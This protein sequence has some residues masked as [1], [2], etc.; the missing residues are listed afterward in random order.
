MDKRRPGSSIRTRIV[1]STAAIVLVPLVVLGAVVLFSLQQLSSDAGNSV[2]QSRTAL[3]EQV[4]TANLKD[5]AEDVAGE[6][7]IYLLERVKDAQVWA[8][9]PLVREASGSAADEAFEQRLAG[10]SPETLDARFAEDPS[11]GTSPEAASY[12]ASQIETSGAFAEMFFTDANGYNAAYSAKT[13]DFVQSDEEWWQAA[14]TKG[15]DVSPIAYDD[16]AQTFS[17]DIAVRIDSADGKKL[18]VLKAV[19]DLGVVQQIADG[20][21]EDRSITILNEDGLILAETATEHDAERIMNPDVVYAD[22]V[23]PEV[24]R[25]LEAVQTSG[26]GSVITDE[27]AVGAVLSGRSEQPINDFAGFDWTVVVEQP[28]D[29]AFAPIASIGEVKESIDGAARALTILVV[30]VLVLVAVAAFAVA[31]SLAVRIVRPILRLRDAADDV[32][33]TRLPE[34]VDS[35]DRLQPGEHLPALE[36][37]QV[38]TGD[39]IEELSDKFNSVIDTAT[40]LAAEQ[41]ESRRRNVSTA[42]VSMGRRNQSLIGRQLKVLDD[43]ERNESDPDALAGLFTLDQLATR[44]RRNAESL[45]VLAGLEPT[46]TWSQPMSLHDVVR[47]ALSEIEDFARI[48]I[49]DI[50]EAYLPGNLVSEVA[51][52]VAELCENATAFSPPT[53]PVRV[54]GFLRQD[55]YRLSITDRGIGMTEEQLYEAN[56]KLRN[57]AGFDRAPS[58]YLGHFV[59]GRLAAR[60][61]IEVRLFEPADQGLIARVTI[62]TSLLVTEAGAEPDPSLVPAQA[63]GQQQW[64]PPEPAYGA[65]GPA[66]TAY[67][68]VRQPE[69]TGAGYAP[70]APSG[71]YGPGPHPE[72]NGAGH[73]AGPPQAPPEPQWQ[74]PQWELP[75]QP[76][77]QPPPP[78]EWAPPQRPGAAPS[79][80]V[81]GPPPVPVPPRR[82]PGAP[83]VV[84]PPRFGGAPQPPGGPPEP[85]AP[86]PFRA[87]AYVPEPTPSGGTDWSTTPSP[88]EVTASGFRVRERKSPRPPAP[89]RPA[90]ATHAPRPRSAEE[91][92]STLSSF[93]T[94]VGQGRRELTEPETT[95]DRHPGENDR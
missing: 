79:P 33:T 70:A 62:P 5:T 36:P 86:L 61:G 48:D 39:E 51:H 68:T 8:A 91:A 17:S 23:D 89:T 41:V 40:R 28:T 9:D 38:P 84:T 80:P 15:V 34:L 57:P 21:S 67:D 7:D 72:S 46:R 92:R 64:A 69:P 74:P 53:S 95:D 16:S 83:P 75:Q 88:V 45:L 44:M 31:R 49:D 37:I 85:G 11:L 4:V 87:P 6:V 42:F 29:V 71:A 27:Q 93:M 55:G 94:G 20:L 1:R 60:L 78:Q 54:T 47:S 52:L 76:P 65:T 63:Y 59:V 81:P 14:W 30:L 82:F 43:L 10:E 19:L 58:R 13:S 12:L 18:G 77:P 50:E 73:A 22:D 66:P 32:A 3:S 56:Q 24:A 26:S 25:S 35:I 2:D 90:P